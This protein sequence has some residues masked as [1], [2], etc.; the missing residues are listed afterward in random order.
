MHMF[1]RDDSQCLPAAHLTEIGT[2]F[3]LWKTRYQLHN[4]GFCVP[5][6]G[7]R[8]VQ[9]NLRLMRQAQELTYD[10]ALKRDSKS[11][12]TWEFQNSSPQ[13]KKSSHNIHSCSI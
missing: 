13:T 6:G 2:Q 10:R 3:S 7:E 1:K 12:H 9:C 4:H 11:S 8:A 5:D